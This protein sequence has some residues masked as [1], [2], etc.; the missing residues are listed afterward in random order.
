[1]T[2]PIAV[3]GLL[4]GHQPL[5]IDFTAAMSTLASSVV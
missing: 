1:M 3:G 4:G 2:A 5:T